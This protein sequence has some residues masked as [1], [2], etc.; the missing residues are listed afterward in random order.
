MT[1]SLWS[2]PPEG[3]PDGAGE[4]GKAQAPALP[5]LGSSTLPTQLLL[6]VGVKS[7]PSPN[8]IASQSVFTDIFASVIS[9][10]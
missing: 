4:K 9:Q 3:R 7:D 8:Q 10:T 6:L 1:K 2:V 5:H